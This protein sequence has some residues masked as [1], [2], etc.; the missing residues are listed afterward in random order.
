MSV[1]RHLAPGVGFLRNSLFATM[2]ILF[3][4]PLTGTVRAEPER[5]VLAQPIQGE[6]A[7]IK[8]YDDKLLR[9]SEILGALHFLRELC[10]NNDGMTWR[11]RM[12]ELIDAEGTS[13]ARRLR[14]TRAFNQGYRGY[15]RSYTSCTPTARAVIERFVAE[16][17]E[18]ADGL[19]STP[20]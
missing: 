18:I 4:I 10:G 6:T 3:I 11:D 1:C 16:G 2:L 20:M 14:L 9:L 17:A 12:R 13:A 15:S 19:A 7:D 8:P 5:F